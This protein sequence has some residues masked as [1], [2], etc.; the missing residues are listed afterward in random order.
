M[1]DTTMGTNTISNNTNNK[2]AMEDDYDGIPYDPNAEA[3]E[4]DEKS[5]YEQVL[6]SVYEEYNDVSK[7]V[8]MVRLADDPGVAQILRDIAKEEYTHGRHLE[9]ILSEFFP[10]GNNQELMKLKMKAKED[11]QS[12]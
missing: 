2:V 8:A 6:D 11:L 4:K 5:L 10:N 3:E 12:V 9:E 7:Y 1:T